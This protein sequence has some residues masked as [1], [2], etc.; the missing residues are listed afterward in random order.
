[1]ILPFDDRTPQE[2]MAEAATL[3]VTE[4]DG[5][6]VDPGVL[7]AGWDDAEVR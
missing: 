3:V 7:E 4:F 5:V 2:V 6:I 1:M